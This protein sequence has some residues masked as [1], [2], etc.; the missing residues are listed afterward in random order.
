MIILLSPSLIAE[1]RKLKAMRAADLALFTSMWY[2]TATSERLRTLTILTIWIFLWDD[3]LDHPD[4]QYTALLDVAQKHREETLNFVEH[5]LGLRQA[6]TETTITINLLF[7]QIGDDFQAGY[8]PEQLHM[9]Y[10]E[11]NFSMAMSKRE[12]EYRV[13]QSIPSLTDY[14]SIRMG[15]SGMGIMVACIEFADEFYVPGAVR[16][17]PLFKKIWD[18]TV[19]IMWM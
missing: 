17:D 14:W 8:E 10:E 12:Q 18:E 11:M 6:P 16:K 15:S 9:F 7:R 2:P 19:S 13:K 1:E 3:E 5:S 4:G